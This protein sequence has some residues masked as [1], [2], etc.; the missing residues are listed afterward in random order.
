M[1]DHQLS[2]VGTVGVHTREDR[3]CW[4]CEKFGEMRGPYAWCT[5]QGGSLRQQPERGCAF[6]VRQPGAD[7]DLGS[8]PPIRGV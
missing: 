1:T 4:H 2:T 6:W 3:P 5:D 7:D 8:N